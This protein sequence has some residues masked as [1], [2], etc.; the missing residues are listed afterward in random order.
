MMDDHNKQLSIQRAQQRRMDHGP[1]RDLED[2]LRRSVEAIDAQRSRPLSETSAVELLSLRRA[3]DA[4]LATRDERLRAD[5][6]RIDKELSALSRANIAKPR[7]TRKDKGT[8]R[9]RIRLH[10]TPLNHDAQEDV[11]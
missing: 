11:P 8:T 7:A 9:P 3:I 4:E 2:R 10:T 5:R 6:A 1:D